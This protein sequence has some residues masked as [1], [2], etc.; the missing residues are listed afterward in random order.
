MKIPVSHKAKELTEVPRLDRSVSGK[1]ERLAQRGS[2]LGTTSQPRR[3]HVDQ[4]LGRE[5]Q[6]R[7]QVGEGTL[8]GTRL[9][10][11]E[12]GRVRDGS[13]RGD[14]GREDVDLARSPCAGELA[15]PV[16]VFHA[17][18]LAAAASHSSLPSIGML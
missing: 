16:A 1:W 17:R 14:Q 3:S 6:A 13:T 7:P 9:N 18:C 4:L 2:R 10:A 5:A 8:H 15:P 11:H 12:L